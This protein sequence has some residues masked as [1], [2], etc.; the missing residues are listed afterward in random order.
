MRPSQVRPHRRIADSAVTVV[1][2]ADSTGDTKTLPYST[3][4]A[5]AEAIVHERYRD[6]REVEVALAS[7]ADFAEDPPRCAVRRG[8]SMPGRGAPATEGVAGDGH[9]AS[10]SV[11]FRR[12]R[13]PRNVHRRPSTQAPESSTG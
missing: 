6:R 3:V 9:D 13:R 12:Y 4:L 1:Q 11:E 10:R 8:C 7:L 2:R 5:T